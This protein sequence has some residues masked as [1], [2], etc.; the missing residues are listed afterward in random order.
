[1]IVLKKEEEK[2]EAKNVTL[3]YSR[4]I[5]IEKLS[6]QHWIPSFVSEINVLLF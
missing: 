1:M 2:Y 5:H 4:E 3:G 6:I